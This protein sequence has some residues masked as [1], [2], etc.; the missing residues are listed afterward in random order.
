[1]AALNTTIA[2]LRTALIAIKPAG[3]DGFE[4]LIADALASISGLVFRLAKSGS[5]F[6]R[7]AMTAPNPFAVA[8]EAKRYSDNLTLD[9]L[10]GKAGIATHVL[11]GRID[12][13]V[14]AA[15]SAVG[16][17]IQ[18]K[19]HDMLAK[20]GIS[21]LTLD[22]T[23]HPLPP[24]AVLL[25]MAR[26]K[27]ETWFATH[28]PAVVTT[29]L[30]AIFDE[31]IAAP[32]FPAQRFQLLQLM[33]ASNIGLDALR[34]HSTTWLR[35]R[36]AHRAKSQLAFGQ[37]ITV[38]DPVATVVERDAEMMALDGAATSILATPDTPS[39]ILVLGE[40]GC[41]KTW[42]ISR[43]LDKMPEPPIVLFVAG[44]RTDL[45]D[46]AKPVRSL[47]KLFAEQDGNSDEAA[48]AAWER[49]LARW[50]APGSAGVMRFV[51]VLDG[52]NEHAGK[53]WAS[54]LK[55]ML[56]TVSE[57]GGCLIASCRPMYWEREISVRLGELPVQQRVVG[58]Y[59][60]AELAVFLNRQGID[61]A[62][63]PQKVLEFIR[64]PRVCSV[65]LKLLPRLDQP[66]ALTV[67]RLLLEYWRARLEEKSDLISHTVQEF[68]RLLRNHAKEW[69][70]K[71][72]TPFDRY[73]WMKR[74]PVAGVKPHEAFAND[75]TDIE[76]GRF[77]QVSDI[78]GGSYEFK[79][80]A[81][82][83]AIGLLI[84]QEL[85]SGKKTDDPRELLQRILE[86]I[87]G[88]DVMSEAI[89]AATGL[90]CLDKGYPQAARVALVEA[91]LS[92]QNPFVDWVA[93]LTHYVPECPAA[94]FDVA[95]LEQANVREDDLLQLLLRTRD[96]ERVRDVVKGRILKWL[97]CWSRQ[98]AATG[99]DE[100]QAAHEAH[101]TDALGKLSGFERIFF[102][103]HCFEM[104]QNSMMRLSH[105]AVPL[106]A[107]RPQASLVTGL[108]AV[109]LAS[110]VA[111]DI[112]KVYEN[113]AWVVR[114]NPQDYLETEKA[115]IQQVDA[116][117]LNASEPFRDAAAFV[118]RMLG[119]NQAVERA[120]GLLPLELGQGWR[121][122][123]DLCDTNPYDPCAPIGSNLDN[124]RIA[125]AKVVSS[126]VW[127]YMGRTVES[128]TLDEVT[129][130]L[131]RFDAP[132][133]IRTLRTV[134]HSIA[135]RTQTPLRQLS[136]HLPQLSPLFDAAAIGVIMAAYERLINDP[137]IVQDSDLSTVA[138]NILLSLMPHFEAEAQLTMLLKLPH[139]VEPNLHLWHVLKVLQAERLEHHLHEA[140]KRPATPDL[141]RVLFFASGKTTKLT[142]R[143]R[144]IVAEQINNTDKLVAGCAAQLAFVAQDD[145]LDRMIIEQAKPQEEL[146]F[147]IN[148]TLWRQRAIAEAVISQ[149]RPDLLDRVSPQLLTHVATAL[150][151]QADRAMKMAIEHRLDRL[152][153]P[154]AVS[155]PENMKMF[156]GVTHDGAETK[157]WMEHADKQD[158]Y[159]D[160][161]TEPALGS[162]PDEADESWHDLN[163]LGKDL[164]I[165][166]AQ[167]WFELD[168]LIED[169]TELTSNLNWA[170]A[171]LMVQRDA[172]QVSRWLDKILA[173]RDRRI[174]G[175]V[176]NFGIVLA[177]AYARHD[178]HKA[179]KV[180]G[181]LRDTHSIVNIVIGVERI[182]LY[183][184]TLFK[185]AT[186]STFV[187]ELD[188]LRERFFAEALTDAELETGVISA[189][190]CGA[191]AW[192][193]GYMS[194]LLASSHPGEQA[195][196]LT[197]A[198]LCHENVNAKNALAQSWGGGFLGEVATHAH[199]LYQ[200]HEWA[201]HWFA[202]AATTDDPIDFWRYGQL[203]Q[204]I[205][206][207]RFYRWL[208]HAPET[209]MSQRFGAEL[210]ARL[211]TAAEERSD[212][213]KETLFG[214]K[215]PD[216]D[217][218]LALLN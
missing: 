92:M 106:M 90:A 15:T 204:G 156:V 176:E 142:D 42:V 25:S 168:L 44:R 35:E 135:N 57:L 137:S 172:A 95:E 26:D 8:M 189:D 192:L 58:G 66:D 199:K 108:F 14:L 43:W 63:L 175:N 136:R 51:I 20:S 211:K 171:D 167:G 74:S 65:A 177:G 150:G 140:L 144:G 209:P 122:V 10:L 17:D 163:L 81:L 139:A 183:L 36:F 94:F 217:I 208:E 102:D 197:I 185:T 107:G 40:E 116:I 100:R 148:V 173:I 194:R 27:A 50:R 101:I 85:K 39:L 77:M 34:S 61:P 193:D 7:D 109:K 21:L 146:K 143:V 134:I 169:A 12:L 212:K 164:D 147:A 9:D 187:A 80:E 69:L 202:L 206:D 67:E 153:Q 203:A 28:G 33:R 210:I 160:I 79:Q 213:R 16:D 1:L 184:Q 98:R 195:R 48:I 188:P 13:W 6:G 23:P 181:H 141:K 200:K 174:L 56:P 30:R 218:R 83:F 215:A 45:L 70:E 155:E 115:L 32:D 127:I 72:E 22:W 88:F 54:I 78:D 162:V 191:A 198:G 182:P 207:R 103:K 131:A 179:I 55:S 186:P 111:P 91:S 124:A 64:N 154:I 145:K 112:S 59:S 120:D 130:A 76:E 123:E 128:L 96:H 84:I 190:A 166:M 132:V 161:D 53:P 165:F 75:L 151:G 29:D 49:R 157:R 118:L 149:K 38:A 46:P 113:L 37:Y 71:P 11:E 18:S 180:L 24:L 117:M 126:Q 87:R 5:Q 196:G 89:T 52:L 125:A 105:I 82:P 104:Q 99:D 2:Q 152:L 201:S 86:P 119:T 73:Q 158:S 138:N 129:P 178:A 62:S 114:L 110:A 97:G 47:A 41:G 31:I 19:L 4:G 60:E 93:A 68:H 3:S 170:D 214:L 205:A 216:N 159:P 121:R 133:I